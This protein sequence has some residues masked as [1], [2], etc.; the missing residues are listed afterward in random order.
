VIIPNPPRLQCRG[1]CHRF[2]QSGLLSLAPRARG[3]P[4]PP[5]PLQ[6]PDRDSG[7]GE[8][9]DQGLEPKAS[10]FHR[11]PNVSPGGAG[12]V[13]LSIPTEIE[14]SRRKKKHN[15][16]K[17]SGGAELVCHKFIQEL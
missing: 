4:Q 11:S 2:A 16:N 15:R 14:L 6:I 3:S 1:A 17:I 9:G 7:M 10:I 8:K 13:V 5:A 12:C